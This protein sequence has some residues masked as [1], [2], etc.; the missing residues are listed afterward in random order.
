MIFIFAGNYLSI[1][2]DIRVLVD[3]SIGSWV[4]NLYIFL[5]LF[6]LLSFSSFYYFNKKIFKQVRKTWKKSYFVT[7]PL[8]YALFLAIAT[9]GGLPKFIHNFYSTKGSVE[10]TVIE[11]KDTMYE[12]RCTPRVIVKEVTYNISDGYICLSTLVFDKLHV[13]SKVVAYGQ[14]SSFGI[15][16]VK[17]R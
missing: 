13:G 1:F 14:V 5:F 9:F 6:G 12:G 4:F 7:M 10:L 2:S 11:K 17:V 3:N 16:I 15:E 8:L